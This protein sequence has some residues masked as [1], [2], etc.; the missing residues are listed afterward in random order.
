M[1]MHTEKRACLQ[2]PQ[3][4]H[5]PASCNWS[6]LNTEKKKS[7]SLRKDNKH[8][9]MNQSPFNLENLESDRKEG[10]PAYFSAISLR[11][12]KRK[13]KDYC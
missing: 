1:H 11:R 4:L 13:P 10:Y 2:Q 9:K 5:K 3:E 6:L 12:L 8:P 7:L